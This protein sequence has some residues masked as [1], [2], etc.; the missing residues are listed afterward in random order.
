MAFTSPLAGLFNV[1]VPST[2]KSP[3]TRVVFP[4]VPIPIGALT[5][6]PISI[7]VC[8]SIVIVLV[9]SIS[10]VVAF[11]SIA[12]AFV[13]PILIPPVPSKVILPV[14]S[15]IIPLFPTSNSIA[16]AFISILVEASLPIVI[17]LAA[18]S[19]PILIGSVP[20]VSISN[21]P[22]EL[23]VIEPTESNSIAIAFTSTLVEA[24]LPI[25]IVLALALVP[26]LIAEVS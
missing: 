24:S 21:V 17:V 18:L 3:L 14:V 1:K 12:E 19:V 7:L 11:K 23:K 13:A 10:N 26:I 4:L 9:A 8:A 6:L 2:I 20:T 16:V 5:L 22:P 15:I 25:L